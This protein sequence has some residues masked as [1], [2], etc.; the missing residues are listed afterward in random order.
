VLKTQ[1]AG[2]TAVFRGALIEGPVPVALHIDNR[3]WLYQI[4][5]Q[6]RTV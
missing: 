2:D 4:T 5:V 6:I 3:S 1:G